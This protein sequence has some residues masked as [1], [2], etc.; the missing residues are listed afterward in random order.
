[1]VES[2]KQGFRVAGEEKIEENHGRYD[3][4]KE[5]RKREMGYFLLSIWAINYGFG[6]LLGI[7]IYCYLEFSY[8]LALVGISAS[9]AAIERG[10][11]V[12]QTADAQQGEKHGPGATL[13]TFQEAGSS[14]VGPSAVEI[15]VHQDKGWVVF[16]MRGNSGGEA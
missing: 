1:M 3:S 11:I 6:S 2:E 10:E 12:A 13:G 16:S 5:G 15:V 14:E 9:G 7:A 8:H 4:N